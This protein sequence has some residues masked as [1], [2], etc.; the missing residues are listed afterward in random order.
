M[1]NRLPR[2]SAQRW[3]AELLKSATTA[4]FLCRSSV[5][6]SAEPVRSSGV[7]CHR[8]HSEVSGAR[9]SSA[10]LHFLSN[11]LASVN[12]MPSSASST[13]MSFVV[14]LIG[15]SKLTCVAIRL[16]HEIAI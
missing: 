8:F 1:C 5:S 3:I 7:H 13:S 9:D 10:H 12:P 14:K 6:W 15:L 16:F 4:S 2:R 11:R